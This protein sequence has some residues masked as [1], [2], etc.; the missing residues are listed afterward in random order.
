LSSGITALLGS[1]R[2]VFDLDADPTAIARALAAD[3]V[4]GRSVRNRPGLRVPGAWDG[5]EIAVRAIAGQQI[6]VRAATAICARLVERF[7][8]RVDTDA[9]PFLFPPARALSRAPLEGVGLTGVKAGAIRAVARALDTG[10]LLLDG[11]QPCERVMAKLESLPGIGPWTAGYISMRALGEP[12]AFPTGD[13]GLRRV[14][15]GYNKPASARELLERSAAWRPWRAYATLH[16]WLGE[17]DAAADR[18]A[19]EEKRHATTT[20][21]N[22]NGVRRRAAGDR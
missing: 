5:L 19:N 12:D 13:L 15:G 7:G 18:L 11:T 22:R 1:I 17:Q 9:L 20:R 8:E 16:A 2:R 4:L 10:D 14:L 21:G 6:S 3:P